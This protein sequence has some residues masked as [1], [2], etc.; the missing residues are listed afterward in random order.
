MADD[1]KDKGSWGALIIVVAIIAIAVGVGIKTIIGGEQ[2]VQDDAKETDT[3]KTED[4]YLDAMRK[5]TVM[6]AA[7][8]Y[9]TGI[10]GNKDTAFDDAHKTCSK[11]YR[12]WVEEDFYSAVYEDWEV[13]KDEIVDDDTLE[14]IL[15][16]LKW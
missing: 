16:E 15:A 11:W 9:K 7:D 4:K 6:E 13:R 3:S 2:A 5:C 12:E 14:Q 8:I 1:G 10:G